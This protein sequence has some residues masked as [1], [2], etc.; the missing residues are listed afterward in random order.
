MNEE[1]L[2]LEPGS[3]KATSNKWGVI[4]AR[5]RRTVQHPARS[6]IHPNDHD[7]R[8]SVDVHHIAWRSETPKRLIKLT[9]LL[10]GC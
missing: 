1:F 7:R 4:H 8:R 5:T 2:K 9:D 3:E 6:A 10:S